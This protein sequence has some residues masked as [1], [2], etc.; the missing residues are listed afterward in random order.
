MLNFNVDRYYDDFEQ[1]IIIT[2]F[3][4]KTGRASS[5]KRVNSGADNSSESNL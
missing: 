2:R 1:V 4:F 5:S 3:F